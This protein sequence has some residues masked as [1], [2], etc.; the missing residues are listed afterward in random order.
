M[1][2]RADFTPPTIIQRVNRI[3]RNQWSSTADPTGTHRHSFE[4]A[5]SALT[6][7]LAELRPLMEA[8]LPALEADLEG[9]GAPWT[10]VGRLPRWP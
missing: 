5:S 3:V 7:L 9:A 8:D 6:E 2:D 10:P 4:V 1:L